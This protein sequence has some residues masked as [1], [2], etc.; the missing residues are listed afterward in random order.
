MEDKNTRLADARQREAEARK[1]LDA[2]LAAIAAHP[3]KRRGWRARQ[4]RADKAFHAFAAASEERADAECEAGACEIAPAVD[5]AEDAEGSALLVALVRVPARAAD[6]IQY[7]NGSPAAWLEEWVAAAYREQF[8]AYSDDPPGRV[9]WR[10][11]VRERFGATPDDA[12]AFR[13]VRVATVAPKGKAASV[14]ADA[15]AGEG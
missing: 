1:E 12:D 10:K 8:A 2:A 7:G 15:L 4:D 3:G 11:T 13:C 9:D 5:E 14:I 6:A